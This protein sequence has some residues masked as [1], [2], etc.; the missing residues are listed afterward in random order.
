MTVL[1]KVIDLLTVCY[2]YDKEL[3]LNV[4]QLI[5]SFFEKVHL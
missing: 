3:D 4:S 1:F 5:A 2:V